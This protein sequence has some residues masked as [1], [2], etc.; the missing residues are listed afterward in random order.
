MGEDTPMTRS[1]VSALL[2]SGLMGLAALTAVV[3]HVVMFATTIASVDRDVDTSSAA[4]YLWLGTVLAASM[5][6][7]AFVLYRSPWRRPTKRHWFIV[8]QGCVAAAVA[9]GMWTSF[10][11]S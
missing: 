8:I 9:T 10:T 2:V 5:A 1:V 7:A 11:A 6:W 4:G 3:L